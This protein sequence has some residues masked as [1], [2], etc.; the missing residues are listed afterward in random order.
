M[1]EGAPR[2]LVF[3][4]ARFAMDAAGRFLSEDPGV[5]GCAW[6]RELPGDSLS[7]VL[8]A[9]ARLDDDSAG[10]PLSGETIALP[11]Y[12][13]LR[14]SVLRLPATWAA[15]RRSVGGA[16]LVL[17]KVPGVLG[18]LAT[19]SARRRGIPV[20]AEVVGDAEG[21]LRSGALGAAGR[22][23]RPVVGMVTRLVV[24][25]ARAVR[26]VTERELQRRYPPAPHAEVASFSDV[27][28]A[29]EPR[30]KGTEDGAPHLVSVG[31]VDQLYKGHHHLIEALG[32]I[33]DEFPTVT[34]TVVGSGRRMPFLH[35]TA[36][37]QG[38]PDAVRFTG[39]LGDPAEVEA[40]LAE[41][42]L[43]V[44][45]SLTE[46][47]PRALIEAMAIGVPAIASRVGGVP[48][49]LPPS[50]TFDPGDVTAMTRLLRELLR[51]PERRREL[52]TAGIAATRRF[53]PS[54]RAAA[55]ADWQRTLIGLAGGG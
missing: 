15:V 16:D 19:L 12:I 55:L 17:V 29:D 41:A 47:M 30:W 37:E 7:P 24:R 2:V 14:Q 34:L 22:L 50:A 53:S 33:R 1:T 31:S 45:P 8:A 11:H 39:Y 10:S 26:Y 36:R 23:L 25:R 44:L 54:A 18:T 35:E 28:I 27:V 52:S 6:A 43:F 48:E 32:R 3:S 38:V 9:R 40:V 21:V 42:T 51:S 46:G 5:N 4:E 49:L 20:A 13:G